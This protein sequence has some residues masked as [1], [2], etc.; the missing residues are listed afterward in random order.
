MCGNGVGS[1]RVAFA[2]VWKQSVEFPQAALEFSSFLVVQ[3]LVLERM[4][5]RSGGRDKDQ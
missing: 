3:R 2:V 4:Q 5:Q 1:C